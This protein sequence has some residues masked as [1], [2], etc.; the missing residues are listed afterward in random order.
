MSPLCAAPPTSLLFS[1]GSARALEAFTD[2]FGAVLR[3]CAEEAS[4][5]QTVFDR[6]PRAVADDAVAAS[7]S[8]LADAAALT[9]RS[10]PAVNYIQNA[11]D[12]LE[13]LETAEEAL[14]SVESLLD[15]I[16][17]RLEQ[18]YNIP[19]VP[20]IALHYEDSEEPTLSSEDASK[21]NSFRNFVE[22]SGVNASP[23]APSTPAALANI[24]MKLIFPGQQSFTPISS[25]KPHRN[26]NY[27]SET[28]DDIQRT[29]A[30]VLPRTPVS[31]AKKPAQMSSTPS[32]KDFGIDDSALEG[33]KA[34]HI[35]GADHHRRA[36]Q[37]DRGSETVSQLCPSSFG[38]VS[39]RL[40]FDSV[41]RKLANSDDQTYE[42]ENG[43]TY[44]EIVTRSMQELKI[45][46]PI[47]VS[48]RFARPLISPPHQVIETPQEVAARF[49]L[50]SRTPSK[51]GTNCRTNRRVLTFETPEPPSILR[52]TRSRSQRMAMRKRVEKNFADLPNFIRNKIGPEMILSACEKLEALQDATGQ[53]RA[54]CFE[55]DELHPII[56]E[57]VGGR[58]RSLVIVALTKLDIIKLEKKPDVP[59]VYIYGDSD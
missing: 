20:K 29:F 59:A 23:P 10:A 4:S 15:D 26:L 1:S 8:M 18:E 32:L 14:S 5:L 54:L 48:E 52:R 24:D 39:S 30:A 43:E 28:S 7:R 25:H 57:A 49:P 50:P 22:R 40:Q 31:S 12:S 11:P 45:E 27:I 13:I 21:W 9:A 16:E 46:T 38:Q 55:I 44:D 36:D 51:S 19:P 47:Q 17:K 58:N 37:T 56:E 6:G 3:E 33:L 42:C 41:S 34:P 35:L 53:S 2:V